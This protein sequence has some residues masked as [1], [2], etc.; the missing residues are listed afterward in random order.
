M[1]STDELTSLVAVISVLNV[2]VEELVSI[3]DAI[4]LTDSSLDSVA[5]AVA[6]TSESVIVLTELSAIVEIDSS[7]AVVT[8]DDE[9][10]VTTVVVVRIGFINVSIGKS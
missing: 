5:V 9:I 3:V 7:V 1:V 4:V 10:V 8:V 2:L 6:V